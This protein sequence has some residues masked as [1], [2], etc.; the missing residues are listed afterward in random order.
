MRCQFCEI[1]ETV[2]HLLVACSLVQTIWFWMG[3]CQ[4][5]FTDWKFLSDILEFAQKLP[6]YKK[7]KTFLVMM[8]A[9][10]WCVEA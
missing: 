2:D 10:C 4:N 5:Y 8:S 6:K 7:K 9:V 1:V 3:K